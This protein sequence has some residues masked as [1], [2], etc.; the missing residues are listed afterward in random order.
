[1]KYFCILP[2]EPTSDKVTLIDLHEFAPASNGD[3][4]R[5]NVPHVCQ[6]LFG[7]HTERQKPYAYKREPIC[8]RKELQLLPG[9]ECMWCRNYWTKQREEK[10]VNE[11]QELMNKCFW[12]RDHDSTPVTPLG[13]WN[14]V[15]SEEDDEEDTEKSK[16]PSG[17]IR[18][19]CG[20]NKNI[21]M[22]VKKKYLK[23]LLY[24]PFHSKRSHLAGFSVSIN[25]Y[26]IRTAE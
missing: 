21:N 13:F 16:T 1:M 19:T 15:F 23:S 3:T 20:I 25:D 9:Q 11:V 6:N 5:G 18:V 7:D 22:C 24:E 10:G 8:K 2:E 12:H 4:P 17:Y 26:V 14:L